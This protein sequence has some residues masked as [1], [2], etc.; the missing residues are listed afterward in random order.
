MVKN[1]FLITLIFSVFSFATCT[2]RTNGV[3]AI[4]SAT[5][6]KGPTVRTLL[7]EIMPKA[8]ADGIV[9]IAVVVNFEAGKESR[10]LIEGC[11]S[12]G[13]SM[14]FTVDTFVTNND[15]Q[16]C[17]ELFAGIA[18]ADYDGMIFFKANENYS[19]KAL[20]P[21]YNSRIEFLSYETPF[22]DKLTGIVNMRIMAANL[23]GELLPRVQW[24]GEELFDDY[25]W[26]KALKTAENTYL[27]ISPFAGTSE[28]ASTKRPGL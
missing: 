8:M 17:L 11:V 25:N 27:R 1:I 4:S 23:A 12:E 13:R 21:V 15:E 16:R 19:Y 10:Q 14:G 24:D 2:A 26:M 5:A 28:T 7:K 22:P 6:R 9:K 3:D 18:R 20:E